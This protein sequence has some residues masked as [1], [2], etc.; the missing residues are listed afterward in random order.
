MQLMVARLLLLLVVLPF[1]HQQQKCMQHHP[2]YLV[3]PAQPSNIFLLLDEIITTSS[4]QE[5]F[6]FLGV[7]HYRYVGGTNQKFRDLY[8]AYCTSHF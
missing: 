1:Q 3:A 6:G 8:D 7:G 5:I 4:T 2:S